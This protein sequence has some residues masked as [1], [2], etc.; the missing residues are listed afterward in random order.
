MNTA[1]MNMNMNLTGLERKREEKRK[2]I[3]LGVE[4]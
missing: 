4:M 2:T 3:L 1:G